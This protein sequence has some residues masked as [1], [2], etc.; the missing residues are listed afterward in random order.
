MSALAAGAA[1][2]HCSTQQQHPTCRPLCA[3]Q[4]SNAAPVQHDLRQLHR[5][6]PLSRQHGTLLRPDGTA[7]H[8]PAHGEADA[9]VDTSAAQREHTPRHTLGMSMSPAGRPLEDPIPSGAHPPPST[10]KPTATTASSPAFRPT[11]PQHSAAASTTRPSQ[12]PPSQVPPLQVPPRS[13]TAPLTAQH[14]TAAPPPPPPQPP[15]LRRGRRVSQREQQALH[16]GLVQPRHSHR[17]VGRPPQHRLLGG[18]RHG[19]ADAVRRARGGATQETQQVHRLWCVAMNHT[20]V[21]LVCRSW[22]RGPGCLSPLAEAATFGWRGGGG[23][24]PARTRAADQRPLD[25]PKRG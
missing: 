19:H 20:Y 13:S 25:Q 1:A 2:S 21:G 11:S 9:A 12:V 5:Q 22:W 16:G 15:H 17:V 18:A 7:W 3:A 23:P 6:Q 8:S 4:H 24:G 10:A 14:S